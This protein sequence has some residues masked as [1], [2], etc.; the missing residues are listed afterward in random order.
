VVVP[1]NPSKPSACLVSLLSHWRE[2]SPAP[3][4]E[5]YVFLDFPLTEQSTNVDAD[6]FPDQR[7]KYA[8]YKN[9][10]AKW[11]PPYVGA[12]N[13]KDFLKRFGTKSGRA[14]GAT[15]ATTVGVSREEVQ[16]HGGWSS[17]A[18]DRYILCSN[19]RKKSV[20]WAILLPQPVT[21]PTAQIFESADRA[22]A[23]SHLMISR[24]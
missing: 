9:A 18:V 4:A 5:D 15:A 24:Q 2:L 10:L 16:A 12:A 22:E 20:G 14:G 13:A 23:P 11:M 21:T 6:I 1:Y 8:T 3:K 17:N 19:D 7:I